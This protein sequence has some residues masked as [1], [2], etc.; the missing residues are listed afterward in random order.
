M[1]YHLKITNPI[2]SPTINPTR[3]GFAHAFIKAIITGAPDNIRDATIAIAANG[4]QI[5]NIRTKS[6]IRNDPLTAMKRMDNNITIIDM[7]NSVSQLKN[8]I[9]LPSF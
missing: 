5:I 6:P 1:K 4:I 8:F 7:I 9:T 2:K 3:I